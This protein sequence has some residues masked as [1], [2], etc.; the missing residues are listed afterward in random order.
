[1]LISRAM[2]LETWAGLGTAAGWK[3]SWPLGMPPYQVKYVY[4]FM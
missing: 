3:W 2:E 1:M 4:A